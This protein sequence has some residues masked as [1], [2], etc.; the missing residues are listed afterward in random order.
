MLA[1]AGRLVGGNLFNFE[2]SRFDLDPAADAGKR[3][4]EQRR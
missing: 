4:S 2:V 3:R 1:G